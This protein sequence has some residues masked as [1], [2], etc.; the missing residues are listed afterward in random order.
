MAKTRLVKNEN[1]RIPFAILIVLL[2]VILIVV[3]AIVIAGRGKAQEDS[4]FADSQGTEPEATERWQEGVITYKGRNY[5]YN[6]A[7]SAYLFMGIDNDEPVAKAKDMVSGGQSDAMFLL[8]TNADD[9]T[10]SVVSINRNTLTEVHVND[11][12]GTD[13][14]TITAQLCTQHGFGDGMEQSCRRTVK[15]VSHL[16]YNQPIKGYLSLNMGGLPKMNDA[17]G[18]VELEVIQ[19]LSYPSAG[20][21]LKKG[22]TVTLNGTE[23]YY[24]LRGRDIHIAGSADQRL[25]RQEQYISC[26]LDKLQSGAAGSATQL[27]GLYDSIADYLVTDIDFVSMVGELSAYEYDADRMYTVP[28]ESVQGVRFSE[29]HVDEDAFYDLIIQLFYEEVEES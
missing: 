20:V 14:G 15:A 5:I 19:D 23:A 10:L 16:F 1:T 6:S 22:E 17:V 9:R 4:Q 3:I 27:L 29:Y 28:G 7:I 12:E 8:I 2:A 11:A 21:D 13:M 25:R 26:Y 24:Y 18:G